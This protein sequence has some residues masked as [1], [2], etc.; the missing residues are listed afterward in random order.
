VADP[1]SWPA[2]RRDDLDG[3]IDLILDSGP[4]TVG[5]ESTV[6]DLS[7]PVPTVLRPGQITME[8]IA[9]VLGDPVVSVGQAEGPAKSP[10]QMEVH[11]AP[12]TPAYRMERG[13]TLK[14]RIDGTVDESLYLPSLPSSPLAVG[15]RRYRLAYPCDA[16]S[17]L[18]AWLRSIDVWGLDFLIIIPPPDEPQWRAI[19][20]RIWRATRPWPESGVVLL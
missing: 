12:R 3:K 11:Y 2:D 7:G 17:Q 1:R 10:G 8:Q 13:Q 4:T 9:A 18:Y 16:E 19:R 14:T 6:L 15:S 5:I 20:D